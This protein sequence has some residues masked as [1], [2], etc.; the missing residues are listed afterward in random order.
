MKNKMTNMNPILS[1]K[2]MIVAICSLAAGWF[3]MAA[4]AEVKQSAKQAQANK[5]IS[6]TSFQAEPAATALQ[7]REIKQPFY[8]ALT[9]RTQEMQ[10]ALSAD[11]KCDFPNVPLS[12]VLQ[13]FQAQHGINIYLDAQALEQEGL[14]ADEPINVSLNGISLK[15]AL[16]IVLNPLGLDYVFDNEVLKVTS[17]EEAN[18]TLI[19]RIYPVADLC[20]KPDDYQ[21]LENVIRNTC[22]DLRQKNWSAVG[23]VIGGPNTQPIPQRNPTISI[24]PKCKAIVVNETDRVHNKITDLLSQLRQVRKDQEDLSTEK[25]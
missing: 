24:V 17:Q 5:L 1:S 14:T 9:K 20:D 4:N 21:A 7:P 12:E 8:P 23:L 10:K 15:S 16:N 11:T 13:F 18:Q 2:L 3:V 25:K 19:V 22:L 6:K